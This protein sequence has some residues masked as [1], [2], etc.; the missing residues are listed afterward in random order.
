LLG[1]GAEVRV[2]RR[3]FAEGIA[4]AND[5]AAIE[6]IVRHAFAFDPT[7]VGKAITVLT[8]KPLL[9]AKVFGF[10]LRALCHENFLQMRGKGVLSQKYYRMMIR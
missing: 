3:E 9:A 8:A 10:F 2:A 1:Q 6:L 5:R 7:A 4:N